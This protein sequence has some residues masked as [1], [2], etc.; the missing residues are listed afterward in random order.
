MRDNIVYNL[1]ATEN[2][3]GFFNALMGRNLMVSVAP[4]GALI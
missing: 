2:T 3:I 1:R 4:V